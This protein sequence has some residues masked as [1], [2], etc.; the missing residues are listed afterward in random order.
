MKSK[1]RWF[2][3]QMEVMT[4]AL[5]KEANI[6]FFCEANKKTLRSYGANVP[7]INDFEDFEDSTKKVAVLYDS[8]YGT[9][10]VTFNIHSKSPV[11]RMSKFLRENVEVFLSDGSLCELQRD[12]YIPSAMVGYII[13]AYRGTGDKIDIICIPE[14]EIWYLPPSH[15]L[16]RSLKL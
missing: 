6:L 12:D 1:V 3:N 14:D 10:N 13:E 4:Y 7:F 5:E 16:R 15:F 9:Y 2:D 8:A 11:G